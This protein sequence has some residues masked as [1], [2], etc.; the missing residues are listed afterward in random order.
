M[1]RCA[2]GR[3]G[4]GG[5]ACIWRRPD[6][7]ENIQGKSI[8]K[9]I[10]YRFFADSVKKHEFLLARMFVLCTH[11]GRP[12]TA[13]KG[14]VTSI[15]LS[16]IKFITCLDMIDFRFI[17]YNSFKVK[18]FQEIWFWIIALKDISNYVFGCHPLHWNQEI[19]HKQWRVTRCTRPRHYS[20]LVAR[21]TSLNT[22]HGK[23]Y[24]RCR[25]QT[26]HVDRFNIHRTDDKTWK[27]DHAFS[28][29][30]F[31]PFSPAHL[32]VF[33]NTPK[34]KVSL[35]LLPL[36]VLTDGSVLGNEYLSW[37]RPTFFLDRWSSL[38]GEWYQPTLM[39]SRLPGPAPR[40]FP[41]HECLTYCDFP[42][43]FIDHRSRGI[44][45]DH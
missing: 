4:G 27:M 19:A 20:P 26:R 1:G 40:P 30:H 29:I 36:L 34:W 33:I 28:N 21:Y 25:H 24:I 42:E 11:G 5:P 17:F 13:R 16:P 14:E 32:P 22:A 8:T 39:A 3:G 38:R 44:V 7:C 23:L 35:M 2:A 41:F 12:R 37:E 15:H 10:L 6:T 43:L 18:S 31:L 45:R 9:A